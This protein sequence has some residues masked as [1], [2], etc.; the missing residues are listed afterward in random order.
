MIEQLLAKLDKVRKQGKG[1]VACCPSHDDSDPS[2]S[3]TELDDGRILIK[4]FAGCDTYEIVSAIGFS[5][6]DLFPHPGLN[7]QYRQFQ[8][9]EITT[10][11]PNNKIEHEKMILEIAKQDRAN[12]K[13]LNPI[14]LERERLAFMRVKKNAKSN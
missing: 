7:N 6:S 11:K 5:L 3:L 14:D 9:L 4:C 8:S 10:K 12:G 1:Y 13:R 2:L